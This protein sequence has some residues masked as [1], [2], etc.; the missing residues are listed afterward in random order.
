[1]T[2]KP[3]YEELEQRIQELERE[4]IEH[5]KMEDMFKNNDTKF[6]ELADS[7]DEIFFGLDK[8]LNYTFWNKTCSRFFGIASENMLGKSYLN[9]E[10]NKGYEWIADIYKEVIHYRQ[11]RNFESSFSMGGK[12]KWYEIKA[13]PSSSGCA[14]LI[15]DITERKQA[16]RSLQKANNELEKKV[17]QRTKKLHNE[18]VER[19]QTENKLKESE[20]NLLSIFDNMQDIYYKLDVNGTILAA[21]PSAVK[22]Y[23]YDS[24]DEIIGRQATDFVYN[25]G[26]DERFSEELYKKGYVRNHIIK[27]KNKDGEPVFVETNTNLIFD[28]QGNPEGVVGVFR[29]ISDRL[30]ADQELKYSKLQLEAVFNNLAA[31]IYITDMDSYEILYTNDHMKKI[32]GKDLTGKICW[33]SIHDNQQGPCDFCANDKL[34]DADGNPKEPYIWELHNHKLNRWYGL[35]DQAIHWIDGRV[36]R[37][38]I[39]FDI[40]DRKQAETKLLLNQKQINEIHKIGI[41]ANSTLS[42]EVILQDILKNTLKTVNA[43]VGMIFLKDNATG[44]LSW[45]ASIG[46]SQNFITAYKS[47]HIQP[48]EGLTGLIAQTGETI[49]IP[50]DSS[51]DPRIAR[52]VI[53]EEKLNSFIGVPIYA[54]DEI[55]GVM[56]TLT[57]Q[58]DVLSDHDVSLCSTI[59]SLVG[60]AIRNAQLFTELENSKNDYKESEEKYRAMMESMKNAAYICS[61]EFK[62][63]YMNP[64]M[65]DRVG[66]DAIGELCYKII[67]D[68][69]KKCSWCVMDELNKGEEIDYEVIDPRDNSY[70]SVSNSPIFHAD[71]NISKLTIFHDITEIKNI[72]AQLQQSR[73]MESIGTLTGGI[74]HDFN[75]LLYM[76]SGNTDLAL[77][78]IPNWNP[79]HQNLQEIKTASLKAAGIVKQLLQF[80]RKTDQKLKPIGA[81]TVIKDCL[82]FLRSTIPSSIEIKTHLPDSE[83]PILADP[84]QINQIM[85]NLSINAS[86]AMEETGG[87]LEVNMENASLDKETIKNYT[88]LGTADNYLKITLSDTGPGIPTEII[89]RIFDPYFTTKDFGKGSGMGLTV[90]H[91][92]LKNHDGSI[93]VSSEVGEGTTFTILFP[94]IDEAPE[95]TT[96]KTVS[97]PHGTETILFV[98][99]EKAIINMMRQIL[100]KLGYSVQ[101]SIN[102][103]EALDLFK[104]K[105][106]S[107]DIVITDMTMPQMAGAKLAEKLKKIRSDIPIILCTGHSSLIDEDKAKQLGISGYVMKP[108]S[109]SKIAKAIREV[110]DK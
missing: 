42:L 30:Q 110:F 103:E 92:I 52:S 44:C 20:E 98:D 84:I 19:K 21:S 69:N 4:R 23:K 105:P 16:E 11:S 24:L 101:T 107:F 93:T 62:I 55:V 96:M 54:A 12:K 102:P 56:N 75:N 36:V 63:E 51:H 8:D 108:V 15:K 100:E 46:L 67:Y 39:A 82:K 26:D 65:I 79:V 31:S 10:F 53:G 95:I 9:F 99:D 34:I 41:I 104:L 58:P 86:H 7:I 17:K 109:M 29:D 71:G 68:R 32:F 47:Q 2:K 97:I 27:H 106:D 3:T 60:S 89:N 59:G 70:H 76:I 22:L 94:V 78:D 74:A 49:Y 83:I 48:G 85:M 45:G 14:V 88:D 18:L 35:H 64:A 57:R 5:K 33:E 87:T 40:T 1:M 25:I 13:Y 61:P 38:E 28:D 77:E 43:S 50:K 80:S 6:H 90:V 37:M 72:E 91:G 81:V 73:K 66:A